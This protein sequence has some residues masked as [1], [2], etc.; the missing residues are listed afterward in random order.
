MTSPKKSKSSAG[1]PRTVITDDQKQQIEKLA[2]VLTVEQ[3]ADFLGIGRTTFYEIMERDEEIS[4]RYKRG[5][6]NAIGG[7][8]K[9]LV[10][11]AMNGDNAA[12]IFYLKTQAGWKEQQGI[13]HISS[14]GSM[15]PK[16]FS[17]LYGSKNEE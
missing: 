9:N 4:V 12:M 7:V 13:D 11:K 5:R 6:A 16:S 17:D 1:R 14:D 2:A 8:A 15:S 10:Q 3:L